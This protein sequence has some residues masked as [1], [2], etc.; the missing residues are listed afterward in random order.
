MTLGQWS[1]HIE[2]GVASMD[3]EHQLQVRLIDAL[4]AQLRAGNDPALGAETLTQLVDVTSVHYLAEEL[5][6]RLY[7]YPQYEMHVLEHGRLMEQVRQVQREQAAGDEAAAL[8][9]IGRLREWL[10][11]H[12]KHHDQAFSLW[13]AKHAIEPA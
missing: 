11:T 13:C 3:T 8:D 4:D 9:T 1:D 12:I 6:M 10:T 5:L 2:T 7:S